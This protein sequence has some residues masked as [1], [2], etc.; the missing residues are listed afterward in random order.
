[1]QLLFATLQDPEWKKLP[2]H[3]LNKLDGG[4]KK[5]IEMHFFRPGRLD[6]ATNERVNPLQLNR[7]PDFLF[8]LA[9]KSP[10]VIFSFLI[11]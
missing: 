2:E 5:R 3:I 7:P 4:N 6:N 8:H 10:A 1:M 9:L 11:R